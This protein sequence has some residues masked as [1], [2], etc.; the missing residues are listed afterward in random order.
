MAANLSENIVTALSKLVRYSSPLDL[1]LVNFLYGAKKKWSF[2]ALQWEM[3]LKMNQQVHI[4]GILQI[5]FSWKMLKS[6]KYLIVVVKFLIACLKVQILLFILSA[7]PKIK[8]QEA[9]KMQA[10]SWHP[11][12]CQKSFW[13]WGHKSKAESNLFS[14]K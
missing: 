3:K 5:F 12:M 2:S 4:K 1:F 9:I 6:N 7:V 13:I 10:L 11:Y 14:Q 8:F